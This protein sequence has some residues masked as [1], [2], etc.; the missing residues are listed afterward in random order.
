MFNT[1]IHYFVYKYVKNVKKNMKTAHGNI[2]QHLSNQNS[3]SAMGIWYVSTPEVIFYFV[4][5]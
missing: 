3:I 2:E 1:S 5:S 4:S